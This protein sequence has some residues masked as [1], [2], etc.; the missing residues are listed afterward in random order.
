MRLATEH[1]GQL[2]Y[3]NKA[4]NIY[5]VKCTHISSVQV[6]LAT[7]CFERRAVYKSHEIGNGESLRGE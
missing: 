1:W 6:L 7:S 3:T 2:H 5:Y 4:H